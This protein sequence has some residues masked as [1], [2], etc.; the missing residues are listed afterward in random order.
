MIS[1]MKVAGRQEMAEI[2]PRPETG[3]GGAGTMAYDRGVARAFMAFVA[4]RF[5]DYP[6]LPS[7]SGR[8]FGRARFFARDPVGIA[9]PFSTR[10]FRI[11]PA[12]QTAAPT[13]R[14]VA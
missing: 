14:D 8:C 7:G 3:F 12:P 11:H 2:D 6:S 9:T 5:R 13:T 4:A 10:S 1:L